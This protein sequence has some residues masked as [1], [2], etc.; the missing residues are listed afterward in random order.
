MININSVPN[1]YFTL[2]QFIE[3][4]GTSGLID[5]LRNQSISKKN[6]LKIFLTLYQTY[7]L[8]AQFA[9]QG[10]QI[11]TLNSLQMVGIA[12]QAI[13]GE[14]DSILESFSYEDQSLMDLILVKGSIQH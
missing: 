3:S 2:Q 10:Y 6:K 7:D 12:H 4:P 5:V 1:G 13:D 8:V 14:F 9:Q 11:S